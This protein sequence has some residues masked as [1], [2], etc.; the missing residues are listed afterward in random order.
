M[1]SIRSKRTKCDE[2]YSQSLGELQNEGKEIN[3]TINNIIETMTI[4]EKRISYLEKRLNFINLK[5]KH[6]RSQFRD[7]RRRLK[8]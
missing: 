6:N 8:K 4:L 2:L 5:K 1:V 7:P 3:N